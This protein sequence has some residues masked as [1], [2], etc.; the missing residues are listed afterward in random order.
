MRDGRSGFW[1]E[2]LLGL[3]DVRENG[4]P[5]WKVGLIGLVAG[6]VGGILARLFLSWIDTFDPG[7][8]GFSVDWSGALVYAA[9]LGL[10]LASL[11]I[12]IVRRR[13]DAARK[14]EREASGS[15]GRVTAGGFR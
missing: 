1:R 4:T 3:V 11:G 8:R 9:F 5:L 6:A 13:R 10:L 14:A 7:S 15:A 12:L 2:G